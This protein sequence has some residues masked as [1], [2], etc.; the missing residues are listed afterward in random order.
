MN[1]P[2]LTQQDIDAGLEREIETAHRAY[3]AAVAT[4]DANEI[5][6][7]FAAMAALVEQRSLPQIRRMEE[8]RGIRA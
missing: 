2:A 4:G 8:S 7:A 5:R 3:L 1:A 6:G